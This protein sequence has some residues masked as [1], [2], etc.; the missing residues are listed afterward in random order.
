M[1]QY[2]FYSN[3]FKYRGRKED[4]QHGIG[5]KL[6]KTADKIV[7]GISHAQ[8]HYY[9]KI[10]DYYG[11][12]KHKYF[13]TKE[14]YDIWSENQRKSGGSKAEQD[15]A[16]KM[17]KQRV[18]QN[19]ESTAKRI[20]EAKKIKQ[21]TTNYSQNFNYAKNA[22][23]ERAAKE[24]ENAEKA[25]RRSTLLKNAQSGRENAIKNSETT[26][27]KEEFEKRVAKDKEYQKNEKRRNFIESQQAA[28][29]AEIKKAEPTYEEAKARIERAVEKEI[30][31]VKK[32]SDRVIEKFDEKLQEKNPVY[33]TMRK[34]QSEKKKVKDYAEQNKA[35]LEKELPDVKKQQIDE[36]NS[37]SHDFD[38]FLRKIADDDDYRPDKSLQ[39]T[40][41]YKSLE[42][43]LKEENDDFV[44]IVDN[45]D[46]DGSLSVKD[47]KEAYKKLTKALE[48]KIDNMTIEDLAR[49]KV[50]GV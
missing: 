9:H 36:L 4:L 47:I 13:E 30:N 32:L 22:E 25:A 26:V 40:P 3:F 23:A 8:G 29:E 11:K 33:K 50:K 35:A 44:S 6:L 27:S 31:P 12:G 5:S 20:A 38:R 39:K 18:A 34:L 42:Q 2:E 14:E 21:E 7:T 49:Q 41:L 24:K 16:S 15:R 10:P 37:N 17:D 46:N 19:E 43:Y 28:R 48:D 1:N 45:F